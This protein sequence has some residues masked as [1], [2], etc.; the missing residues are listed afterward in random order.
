MEHIH[1]PLRM[2]TSHIKRK[3]LDVPYANKSEAQKLDIYLPDEGRG[4]LSS[5]R[6]DPWRRLDVRR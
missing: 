1:P 2:D 4:A 5:H 6:H 3:W